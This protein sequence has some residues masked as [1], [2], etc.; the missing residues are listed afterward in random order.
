MADGSG[1]N[2]SLSIFA[3]P[4]IKLDRTLRLQSQSTQTCLYKTRGKFSQKLQVTSE[5]R[6]QV[7]VQEKKENKRI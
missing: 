5:Q 3:N 4:N 1:I 7:L 6:Q 2:S